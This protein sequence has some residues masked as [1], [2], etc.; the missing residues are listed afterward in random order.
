MTF[1]YGDNVTASRVPLQQSAS[2]DVTEASTS[3]TR[4]LCS[5]IA[6]IAAALGIN[7][8]SERGKRFMRLSFAML[9][10]AMREAVTHV[11]WLE[12]R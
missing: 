11:P 3:G 12:T 7:F 2:I 4:Q 6:C 8:D 5:C 9:H 10:D 1:E